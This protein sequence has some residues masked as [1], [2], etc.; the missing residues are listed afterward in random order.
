[1]QKSIG[2]GSCLLLVIAGSYLGCNSE[3]EP[4]DQ[5]PTNNNVDSGTSGTTDSGATDSGTNDAGDAGQ[6]VELP[7][8]T[9]CPETDF[10]TPKLPNSVVI[11]DVVIK[12][13]TTWTADKIYVVYQDFKVKNHK[14][15]VQPGT[16]ICL[17]QEGK[18][19]VGE[20]IEPGEIHLD[21][22]ADKPIVITSLPSASDATKPARYNKGLQMDTYLGSTLSHVNIWFSGPGGGGA[23]YAFELTS[24]AHGTP[25]AKKGLLVDHLTVGAV[26]AR[27]IKVGTENGIADGS[28]I[29]F[30]GYDEPFSTSPAPDHAFDVN[31]AAIASVAK[32]INITGAKIP[33]VAKHVNTY[34]SSSE[35]KLGST[36]DERRSFDVVDFGLP[37]EYTRTSILQIQG[38]QN[39]PTGSILT[40]H[41]GVT[42]RHSGVIIVGA[43]SGTAQGNLVVQGTAAKPVTFTSAE[44]VPAKGD[45]YGFYFVMDQLD[46]T[47]TRMDQAEIL[48]AG[49]DD[50]NPL[51]VSY[52]VNR[53]GDAANYTGPI[54]ITPK[55]ANYEGPKLSNL[56]ISHSAS[57][58]IVS[59]AS[60]ATPGPAAQ[61]TTNYKDAA[62]NIKIDDTT[63][64]AFDKTG[65]CP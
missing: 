4:N 45:W 9:L 43:T 51:N 47:K 56:H 61:M 54:M 27:G 38:P 41:E 34:T 17:A 53:C 12:E 5:P 23:S 24:T 46:L 14:L 32:A 6:V 59:G 31:L 10:V 21:G 64:S 26:Q 37:Y 42:W 19:I 58:G 60:S 2:L 3:K 62:L 18:I 65:A 40:F 25:D 13:D 39:D 35:G 1:M 20:G 15:T 48:F 11:G 55:L 63:K 57:Y 29:Q 50:S 28:A 36:A 33:D 49:V 52:F 44:A 30:T 7:K 16:T 8:P 22:T